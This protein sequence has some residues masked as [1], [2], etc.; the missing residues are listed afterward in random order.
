MANE[1][2]PRWEWRAFGDDFGGTDN[3]FAGYRSSGT[4]ESDEIYFLSPASSENVKVRDSLLDIK[5]FQRANADGLEQWKP[6]LKHGFPLPA[7]E[8]KAMFEVLGVPAPALTRTEYALQQLID[9]VIASVP[10]MRVVKVHKMRTRYN[11]EGC[12]S[13]SAQV[14]ADGKSTRTIALELEDADK[15]IGAVR[16]LGLESYGN[17]SYPKGLKRLIGMTN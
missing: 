17:V 14:T 7:A 1:I 10:G 16:K 5:K 11:V 2:V 3:P 13:E 4:Q 8:I 15:V 12:M 9:E 6:V